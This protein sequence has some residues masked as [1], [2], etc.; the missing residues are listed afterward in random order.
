[1]QV[2][3]IAATAAFLNETRCCVG[4]GCN[5]KIEPEAAYNRA[6]RLKKLSDKDRQQFAYDELTT[7]ADKVDGG[8]TKFEVNIK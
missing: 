1:M 8:P 5:D 7:L 4:N 3:S 2:D 6:L